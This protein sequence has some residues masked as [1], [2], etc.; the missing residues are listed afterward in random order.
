MVKTINLDFKISTEQLFQQSEHWTALI[1]MDCFK[2][3]QLLLTHFLMSLLILLIYLTFEIN[4]KFSAITLQ[5]QR[6]LISI[7][8]QSKYLIWSSL[9][10][11]LKTEICLTRI[12]QLVKSL[13]S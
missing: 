5:L 11:S 13:E 4:L 7:S 9:I 12:F 8:C 3:F 6:S 1:E 2:I 10:L